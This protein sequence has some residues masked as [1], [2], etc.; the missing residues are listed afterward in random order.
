[1]ASVYRT[2]KSKLDPA[3]GKRSPV[4]DGKGRPVPHDRFRFEYTDYQGRRRT[5][6]G[7]SSRA[8]TAALA[9]RV[10]AGQDE[11]RRGF[12][13]APRS[14]DKARTISITDVIGEYLAWG[15]SQGGR[16][17]RPWSRGHS[18]MRKAHLAWWSERLNLDTLADLE[19]A[20][21]RV[22]AA[23][24]ELS[25][26]GRS[27]KTIENYRDAI[28][29]FCDWSVKRGYLDADPLKNLTAW[30]KTPQ[31]RRRALTVPEIQRLLNT[32][33]P[34]FRPLYELAV[35]SGLRAGELRSLKV[36]N[37]NLKMNGLDLDPA[38]TKNRKAGFQPLPLDLVKRLAEAAQG[39]AQTDP[40]L[41]V[42][43]KT[44]RRF[45][46][47]LQRAG[48]AKKGPGGVLDFHALRTTYVNMVLESGAGVKEAMDLARHS[49]PD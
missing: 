42:P 4:M 44:A 2:F 33:R 16:G 29:A 37:L 38:W 7:S 11:I 28:C 21:S 5:A 34:H 13:P 40:L 32:C 27:G 8:E 3:T 14:S 22:E 35:L 20:L 10:Q 48:I 17:G 45:N 23:L 41:R 47:D 36:H 43:A 25:G 9:N 12:R 39:K 46:E 30:D 26:A 31:T 24:R 19:G 15:N 18:N 6:S 1:M 49:T